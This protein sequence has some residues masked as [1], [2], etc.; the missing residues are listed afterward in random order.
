MHQFAKLKNML[1][2]CFDQLDEY[3][4]FKNTVYAIKTTNSMLL[5]GAY[6]DLP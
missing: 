6:N 4:C 1:L 5:E 3:D 2:N